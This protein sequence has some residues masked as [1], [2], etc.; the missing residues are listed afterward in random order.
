MVDSVIIPKFSFFIF[1]L[2]LCSCHSSSMKQ[3][4]TSDFKK[5]VE[6]TQYVTDAEKFGW[7]IVQLDVLHY[8]IL[9]GVDWRC[10]DGRSYALPNEPVRQVS[11]NDAS[12]YAAWTNTELPSYENYWTYVAEDKRSI[13]VNSSSIL[14]AQQVN[15]I[16]NV[17]EITALDTQGRV[18][19]VGGSYL[20]DKNTCNGTE[21]NRLLY[22]DPTTGNSH[23]GLAVI[24]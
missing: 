11:Y 13:N 19:L 2:G 15:L 14:D 10:P 16:G 21:K 8:E 6:A 7:S 18:R 17:W 20:C 22:V 9:W 1:L 4:T 23:I 5:F 24:H 3:V 12:A